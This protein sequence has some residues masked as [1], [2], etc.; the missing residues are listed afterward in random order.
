MGRWG[1]LEN[2]RLC[3][4]E[5]IIKRKMNCIISKLWRMQIQKYIKDY[6]GGT[7]RSLGKLYPDKTFYVICLKPIS[8]SIAPLVL[9]TCH[10]LMICDSKGGGIFQ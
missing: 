6:E 9:L 5:N 1:Q 4:L 2:V 3:E 8:S 7:K 10:Q